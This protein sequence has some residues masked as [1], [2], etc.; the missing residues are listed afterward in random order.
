MRTGIWWEK[1]E[2][3]RIMGR[4]RL[5]W[6]NNIKAEFKNKMRFGQ[7]STGLAVVG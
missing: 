4:P 6:E 3:R 2:G 5:R 1:T 7:E